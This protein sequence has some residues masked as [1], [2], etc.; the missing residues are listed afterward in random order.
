MSVL[1][2]NGAGNQHRI[3]AEETKNEQ[4]IAGLRPDAKEQ[5]YPKDKQECPANP[6]V[7]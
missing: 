5:A 1:P 2:K 7:R 3:H 6:L 4:G